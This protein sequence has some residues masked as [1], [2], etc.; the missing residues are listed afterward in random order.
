MHGLNLYDYSARQMEPALGR[1][2]TMDPMCEKYYSISPYVY[3]A[4]NPMNA[5]DPNGDSI[6]FTHS[7]VNNKLTSFTMH[8]SG[9]VINVSDNDVNMNAAVKTISNS[10]E[11]VFRGSFDGI[12]FSTEAHLSVAGSMDDVSASDH[13][14]AL[15]EMNK[16]REGTPPGASNFL[17]GKTAFIDADYFTGILDRTILNFGG[18]IAAHEFGHLLNLDHFTAR[19]AN[20]MKQGLGF[21]NWVRSTRLN[22]G[23]YKTIIRAYNFGYLNRGSNYELFKYYDHMKHKW[24]VKKMP[25]RGI[26]TP[27]INY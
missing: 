21:D 27:A 26:S 24:E 5:I 13:V 7:S 6:W 10:L 8:V 23:Q 20:L 4:N 17:G 22:S 16:L 1:F 11:S 15:A 18:Q 25:S 9:K 19:G 2:T 3:V 12:K 14:F